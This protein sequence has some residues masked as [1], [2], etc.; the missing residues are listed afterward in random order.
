MV[1]LATL[2]AEPTPDFALLDS[3]HR[4]KLERCGPYRFIRPEPQAM[5]APAS[6]DWHADGEFTGGSDEEGGGRWRLSP[7]VPASWPIEQAG[8]QLH[9]QCTP[10]R[11]LGFFPDMAPHWQ[12]LADVSEGAEVLN[13]FGYTGAASLIAASRG[14]KVVHVDASKKAVEQARANAQLSGLSDKPI[15]WITED[16]RRF[17][18]R[19]VRRGRRYDAILLD[20]PKFGRGPEGEVWEL[21]EHLPALIADCVKLLDAN[22]RLLILTTYAVRL[23]ALALDGLLKPLAAHLPGEITSGEMAIREEG[24]GLLLPTAIFT[25]WSR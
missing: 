21:T 10:F 5:W 23:S 1:A 15:R 25:R 4:R 14:A 19:E 20:P 17:V 9:A 13:L 24:R 2:V 8:V 22:S 3:G 7:N 11:H 16:A 12:S 18:A 6:D